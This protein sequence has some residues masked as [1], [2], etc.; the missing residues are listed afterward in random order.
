[1]YEGEQ[2]DRGLSLCVYVL[3]GNR[4]LVNTTKKIRKTNEKNRTLGLRCVFGSVYMML[5]YFFLSFFFS[6]CKHW[7]TKG[8]TIHI[9]NSRNKH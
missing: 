4:K 2:P 5:F 3:L 7:N 8:S 9:E 1:M 6:D